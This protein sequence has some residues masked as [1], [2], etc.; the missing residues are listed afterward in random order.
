[1]PLRVVVP[2]PELFEGVKLIVELEFTVPLK[3]ATGPEGPDE[4]VLPAGP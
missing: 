2:P 3:L 4:P 1:M